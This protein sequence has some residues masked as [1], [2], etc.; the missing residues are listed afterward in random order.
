M[1]I[2]RSYICDGISDCPDQS[3][4]HD[5][6][7]VTHTND[8]SRVCVDLYYHCTSEECIPRDQQCDGQA[9]CYD[10]SDEL[11]CP[12]QQREWGAVLDSRLI[13]Q[14]TSKVSSGII[15]IIL[16]Y[17]SIAS[18]YKKC[19]RKKHKLCKINVQ[20]QKKTQTENLQKKQ[21]FIQNHA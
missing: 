15:I 10:G 17:S 14:F 6:D 21:Y 3:D 16:Q 12:T 1:C 19:L 13:Q 5:C 11:D 9:D 20:I 7:Y 4:E 18:I 2:L 8:T